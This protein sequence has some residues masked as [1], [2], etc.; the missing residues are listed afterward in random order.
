MR[1]AGLEWPVVEVESFCVGWGEENP[2]KM[3]GRR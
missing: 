2:Q 3:Y 1:R